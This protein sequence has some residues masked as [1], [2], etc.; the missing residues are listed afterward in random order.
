MGEARR[1]RSASAWAIVMEQTP[2]NDAN[3]LIGSV[4]QNLADRLNCGIFLKEVDDDLLDWP[5][6]SIVGSTP[7][8]ATV[9]K[10][11]FIKDIREKLGFPFWEFLFSDQFLVGCYCADA[12]ARGLPF[13]G[14]IV[15]DKFPAAARKWFAAP[16]PE[17][18][19]W[20]GV[21]PTKMALAAATPDG[22]RH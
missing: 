9:P 2:G 12:Q 19:E 16:R 15:P 22:T 8:I 3:A 18:Y 20:I 6:G 7:D 1:K 21:L 13:P 4:L 5:L 10:C 11:P 14:P 17:K